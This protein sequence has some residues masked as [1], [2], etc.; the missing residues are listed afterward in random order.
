MTVS[1]MS[2]AS[3]GSLDLQSLT[4]SVAA[5]A[6]PRFIRFVN[7]T[8]LLAIFWSSAP[9]WTQSSA[10]AQAGT[11]ASRASLRGSVDQRVARLTHIL[12]LSEA[13]QSAVKKIL[14]QRRQQFWRIRVDASLSGAQR[15]E[16]VRALQEST[17]QEIRSVLTEE[18][19]VRYDPLAVR[20]LEPARGQRSVEDWLKAT[21]KP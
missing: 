15:I 13:Q 17:V 9:A 1:P 5:T 3:G 11:T 8:L 19:R 18:Q 7:L 2:G 6:L 21:M 14:E 20:G 10:P 12:Q 4:G 16:R